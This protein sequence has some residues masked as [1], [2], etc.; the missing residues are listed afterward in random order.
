MKHD[1]GKLRLWLTHRAAL[2]DYACGMTGSKAEAEDVVQDA[3][4]RFVP[5]KTGKDAVEHPLGYLYRIVRNLALDH[6]RRPKAD[7]GGETLERLAS[8]LADPE[9]HAVSRDELR[10]AAQAVQDLPDAVRTAFTL[11]RLEGRTLQ[12]VADRLGVSVPTAHRMVRD[13]LMRIS[14][15]LEDGNG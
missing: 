3:Y 9:H 8:P 15:R 13:A 5:E 4:L 11:H 6:L 12:D 7:H 10:Q 1:E 14:L 2:V